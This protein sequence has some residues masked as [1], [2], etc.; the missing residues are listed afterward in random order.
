MIKYKLLFLSLFTF[1]FLSTFHSVHAESRQTG[2]VD[3][4]TFQKGK[5]LAKVEVFYQ[6]KRLGVTDEFGSLTFKLPAGE[7]KI[8]LVKSGHPLTELTL[9]ISAGEIAELI[10]PI[11]EGAKVF[12]IMAETS[13]QAV[14]KNEQD[15]VE[16]PQPISSQ[17]PKKPKAILAGQVTSIETKAGIPDVSLYLSGVDQKIQTDS[18]GH[19]HISVPEGTYTLSAVHSDYSSQTV[20]K[21]TLVSKK[22]LTQNLEMT[23]AAAQLKAF[24]VTAPRLAGGVLAVVEEKKKT[25][26]VAEVISAEEISKSGDSSAA[27]A[28]SRV[29]GLTLVDGKYIYVRGMGDRYS[30]IRLNSAGLSSPEPSKKTVPLDMFP[31]GMIGSILVQKTFSPNLPGD[32]G[33]GTVLM[34]TKPIPLE[35]SNKFSISVGGNSRST[36]SGGLTYQGGDLD[37]LGYDDGTRQLRNDDINYLKHPD[38]KGSEI[39]KNSLYDLGVN[40][41]N[42]YKTRKEMMMPDVSIKYSTGDRYE[43]YMGD[44]A[45]GYNFAANYSNKAR[46]VKENRLTSQETT[47]TFSPTNEEKDKYGYDK[48]LSLMGNLVYELGNYDKLEATTIVSRST[49]DSVYKDSFFSSDSNNNFKEYG[50]QWE[51][52]QL[53]SQQF[54]GE[55]TFPTLDDLKLEW[56]TSASLSSRDSPDTR[57]Y[58]FRQPAEHDS[59]LPPNPYQFHDRNVTR[60]WESLEDT[61]TSLT[62]DATQP[63]YDFFGATGNLKSGLLYETKN[64]VSDTFKTEWNLPFTLSNA[65]IMQ[66]DN[67]EDIL[68]TD[69]QGTGFTDLRLMNQTQPT[70]SYTAKQSFMAGYAMADLTLAPWLKIMTGGRYEMSS[71]T[72]NTFKD[73]Q[74][75]E[76][77]SN[78]LDD[79]SFLPALSITTP[80][81]QGEQLR[82][83][84]SETLNR[85]LLKELS[86]SV[87]IDPD[88]RDYYTGNPDLQVASIRNYDLRWEKYFSSFENISFA[89]FRKEFTNPIEV[90]EKPTLTRNPSYTYANVK[91]AV[92]QG[93][94]VQGTIWLKRLF[95]RSVSS[96]Y[97]GFNGSVID[98]QINMAGVENSISTNTKRPLQGQAPWVTN[99]NLGYENL[100]ADIQA[101]LLLNVQGDIITKAGAKASADADFG[102]EDTYLQSPASLNFVYKQ[103]IYFGA[104]DKLYMKVKLKNLLDGEYKEVINDEI[105]KRYYKGIGFNISFSY[106]WL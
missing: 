26:A 47:D 1:L 85:P 36:G 103:L 40:L 27:G 21:L 22:Q 79:T 54:H 6:K 71:Q 87:Y 68:T 83:A 37:V 64:R 70:D 35:K 101:N 96:F 52:R 13:A 77:T 58:L 19:Y 4:L 93:A 28:L 46:Y 9:L 17:K 75:T 74:R 31:S 102:V 34:R 32:F 57:T 16:G 8:R 98:S 59:Q 3:L 95:G 60:S 106:K 63:L 45:W 104:E 56:Q 53:L 50:L 48:D 20:R 82:F 69:N 25:S 7:H 99:L 80:Y 100:V 29:T 11:T 67:P 2:E 30:S 42:N 62:L 90:I 97:L 88:T 43:E 10:I 66:T 23:P 89:L 24:V 15:K 18:Q 41:E 78:T 39:D 92:N 44:S 72:I 38:S 65:D 55:H 12:D 105:K 84:Y 61:A 49:S 14:M 33:G 76:K 51:E 86:E 73:Y 81:R 91:E 94:E 5:P